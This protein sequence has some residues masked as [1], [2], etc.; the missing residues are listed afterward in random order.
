MFVAA[1]VVMFGGCTPKAKSDFNFYHPF[2]PFSDWAWDEEHCRDSVEALIRSE[3]L[4]QDK[5]V[6]VDDCMT[7]KG[8]ELGQKPPPQ[9]TSSD[10]RMPSEG[11]DEFY[12]LD[13]TWHIK[14]KAQDR[15]DYLSNTGIWNVEV[16]SK[17]L[18][19]EGYW[20]RV[21]IGPYYQ[22]SDARSAKNKLTRNYGLRNLMVLQLR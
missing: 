14:S 16:A 18:G 15:A 12:I 3:R 11:E 5:S 9:P 19:Y 6:A 7:G 17:D 4:D 8:Y 21:V 10:W 2:K 22:Q 13:S 1:L 20:H